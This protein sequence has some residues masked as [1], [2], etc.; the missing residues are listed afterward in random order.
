MPRRA[1]QMEQEDDLTLAAR[2]PGGVTMAMRTPCTLA[3]MAV[4]TPLMQG[5]LEKR[6]LARRA[7]GVAGGPCLDERVALATV[8]KLLSLGFVRKVGARYELTRDGRDVLAVALE[9]L[10]QALDRMGQLVSPRRVQGSWRPQDGRA[11]A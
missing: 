4:M 3:D 6:A 11:A 2:G 10:R 5:P 8:D 7:L 1:R 9:D